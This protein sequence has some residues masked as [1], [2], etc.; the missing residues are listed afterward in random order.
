MAQPQYQV[1][2]EN[3]SYAKQCQLT[4]YKS[5]EYGQKLN[6]V[7]SC[8]IELHPDDDK[9]Q[10]ATV[11]NYVKIVRGG[12]IVFGGPILRVGWEIP[13]TAPQAERFTIYALDHA[14]YADWRLTLPTGG[15]AYETEGPD[16]CAD[17]LK[18]FVYNNMG[19]GAAAARRFSDL[20]IEADDHD[21]DSVTAT[22]RYEILLNVLQKVADMGGGVDWRFVAGAAGCTFTT[23]AAWGLDRTQGNG[24]NDECILTVDRGNFRSMTY[25][26][27]SLE[28]ANYLYVGGQGDNAVREIVERTTAGDVST[29]GRR[30]RFIDARQ[31]S[32]TASLEKRGDAAL[33]DRQVIEAM[34]CKPI[35]TTWKA[36]TGTTWDLGDIVTVL[37]R[38]WRSFSYDGK[39]VGIKVK[40]TSSGLEVVTPEIESA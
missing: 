14:C 26:K 18:D 33:L 28:H 20:T 32:L 38:R 37:A 25:I 7:A 11:M 16:D 24:V 30:E 6:D 35:S 4:E 36:T 17:V 12:V 21:G 3:S 8:T 9:I 10:Y 22:V 13:E 39:I 19:A 2:I 1:W 27:D 31:L 29:Y 15:T 5:L 34:D 23:A 40:V